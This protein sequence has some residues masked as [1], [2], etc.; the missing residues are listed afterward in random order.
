MSDRYVR[1]YLYVTAAILLL[2]V[3][4]AAFPYTWMDAVHRWLGLGTLA[5]EP[6]MLY[7]ARSASALY[8]TIGCLY[9]FLARD[10]PRYRDLLRFLGWLKVL[11]GLALVPIDLSAGL[12]W[13][14][15]AYEGPFVFG[16]GLGLLA[17]LRLQ[18]VPELVADDQR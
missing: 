12:P 13:F 4:C 11:L 2:A 1:L 16:W 3:P 17:L 6:M 9:F 15:T 10:V 8:A 5:D 7:L 18:P 14:W